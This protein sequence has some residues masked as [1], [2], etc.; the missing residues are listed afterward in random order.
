MGI[1]R[2]QNMITTDVYVGSAVNI[3]ARWAC[4]KSALL[5]NKHWNIHLQ[6]SF[7]KY[8]I[9]NFLIDILEIVSNKENLIQREQYWYDQFKA[10]GYMLYNTN[11]FVDNPMRGKTHTEEVKQRISLLNTGKRRTEEWKRSQK[12]RPTWNKGKT[13]IFTEDTRNR[14]SKS[15]TGKKAT[16]ETRAKLSMMRRGKGNSFYGR[17]HSEESKKKMSDSKKGR[18]AWNKG[19]PMSQEQK[20]KL[21]A[22]KIGKP[23]WNK[24]KTGIFTM[25]VRER[26]SKALK[27]NKNARK[28]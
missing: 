2:I 26:I 7:N 24:G 21:S 28:K 18:T 8:G 9:S 5:K 17:K 10:E 6:R 4:H 15:L 27:G 16:D 12:G 22:S 3:K 11:N 14:I 19:I 25:E 23:S 20:A 1:Y 13:G